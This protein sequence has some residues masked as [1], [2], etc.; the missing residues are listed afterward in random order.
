MSE[1]FNSVVSTEWLADHL[2]APDVRVVDGTY[3]LPNENKDARILYQEAHIRN[4][5]F[6]DIDDI[7]D[8]D[9]P[10][11]HMIPSDI[12]FASKVRKLG[13]G[14]GNRIVVYDQ[15]GLFSAARVWWMFRLFGHKDVAVL[16]GG[17]PKWLSEHRPV[18]DNTVHPGERHFTPRF[19]SFLIRDKE[20]LLRNIETGKEQ[21]LD[22]RASGRF[23]GE[24]PEP[25]AGIRS[26]HIPDSYNLPFTN[27]FKEDG[28]L[29]A[30]QDI[31]STFEKAGI[32]YNKPVVTSC[33][34]GVT[35]AVL[36]LGLEL[37]GHKKTSLYDGS[38]SEWGQEGDTPVVSG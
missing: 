12:K 5:I 33:G 20:Q 17:L 29:K 3:Y 18:D 14:D 19:N 11:P 35:A 2:E 31:K 24:V 34:S 36:S 27:L 21:V 10:L 23:K 37:T 6:F 13:L 38:W 1:K 26:G 32:D 30:S 7:S 28:T 16:D 22:A 25:R 8:T 15:R 9:N 4:A